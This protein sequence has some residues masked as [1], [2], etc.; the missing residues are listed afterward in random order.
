MLRYVI[1]PVSFGTRLTPQLQFFY[2]DYSS[3]HSLCSELDAKVAK[4]SRTA[5]GEDFLTI[6]AL[7]VRQAFG[8][9]Q[10][11]GFPSDQ[12]LFMKEISS[13]G[14]M[15]TVDVIFPAHPIFLYMNPELLRLLLRPVFEL[16]E[17]GKYPNAY[18]MHD[19]GA[20]YPNA[21]GHPDGNDEKM[22]LEECGNM[23]IMALAYAQKS[24][25]TAY[26]ARHYQKLL[27]WAGYLVDDA[28]YPANQISTDDF[29]GALA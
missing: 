2:D 16:Q 18:A 29:A 28:L 15:N 24:G 25:N 3:S 13:D 11:C 10:L 23:V 26:L 4:D 21:T 9:V 5:A 22:P 12:Y 20:H 14:N 19:I 1:P 7:T 17:S 27:Q 8:A 6:I